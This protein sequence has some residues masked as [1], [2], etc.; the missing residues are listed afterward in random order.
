MSYIPTDPA[1]YERILAALDHRGWHRL[2]GLATTHRS[3]VA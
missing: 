2:L 1:F 3:L